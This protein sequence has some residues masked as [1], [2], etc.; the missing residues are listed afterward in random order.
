MAGQFARVRGVVETVRDALLVPQRCIQEQQ[1]LF[2]VF[3]VKDDGTVELRP[4]TPGYKVDQLQVIDT[5]LEPGEQVVFEGVQR[6]RD[7]MRI[8]P[9]PVEIDD[10]GAPIEQ[11]S[12]MGG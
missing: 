12:E 6:L 9:T 4:V 10:K 3:V 7:G 8:A 5:G 11:P 1:G 2:S